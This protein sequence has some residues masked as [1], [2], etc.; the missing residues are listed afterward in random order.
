MEETKKEKTG[1]KC[2]ICKTVWVP[3]IKSCPK[4]EVKEETNSSGPKLLLE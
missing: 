2:P 4:C 3:D 1:W